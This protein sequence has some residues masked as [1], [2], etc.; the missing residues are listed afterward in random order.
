MKRMEVRCC[1][2]PNK[3]LGTLPVPDGA[4]PGARIKFPLMQHAMQMT[5][6]ESSLE[7]EAQRWT[8]AVELPP[9]LLMYA[10][11]AVLEKMARPDGGV[12][13]KRE[14]VT[15][16]TLRLIPGFIEEKIT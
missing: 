12:A 3:L 5:R 16:E 2:T 8:L 6:A 10:Q 4:G 1:C 14:G 13:L 11:S 7:F 15:V 9:E